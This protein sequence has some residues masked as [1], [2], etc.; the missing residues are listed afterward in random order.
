LEDSQ[1]LAYLDGEA[2]PEI[3]A[4]VAQ[5][6]A[7]RRRAGE[8]AQLQD[9]LTAGL[10]RHNC[11]S[12][13]DLGEYQMGLLARA[14]AV[15]ISRHVEDCPHCT[16]ELAQ[17]E[18]YL[19]DLAPDA[20]LGRMEQVKILIAELV[21]G[22]QGLGQAPAFAPA[23][24]FAGLRGEEEEPL[25][26]QAEAYQIV[27]E[28]A[29]DG[30]QPDRFALMALVTGPEID[31]LEARLEG[32]GGSAVTAP[33]DELGNLYFS[34]VSPGSYALY[35]SGPLVEIEIPGLKIGEA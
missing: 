3:V 23:P 33:V 31:G 19:A 25:V 17:L 22:V 10:Y 12:T 21:R 18:A 1:L 13:T 5:C 16:R 32:T 11:P 8:L 27:I 34:A 30:Q 15:A 14:Q 24:V 2:D 9:R 35:L 26:Y 29:R 6:E 4:H 28:V 7:C 20:A